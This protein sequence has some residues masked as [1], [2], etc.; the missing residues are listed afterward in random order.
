MIRDRRSCLLVL[1]RSICN[2]KNAN[3]VS[4]NPKSILR[5]VI[6]EDLFSG[7]KRNSHIHLLTTSATIIRKHRAISFSLRS[8][9]LKVPQKEARSIRNRRKGS[10]SSRG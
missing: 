5:D 9:R 1:E 2:E 10:P 3:P 6:E 4:L 8:A 7:W